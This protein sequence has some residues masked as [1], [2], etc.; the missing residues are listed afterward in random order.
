[1]QTLTITNFTRIK[2]NPLPL[3]RQDLQLLL[4]RVL[5]MGASSFYLRQ[6]FLRTFFTFVA[7]IAHYIVHFDLIGQDCSIQLFVKGFRFCDAIVSASGRQLQDSTSE[8][9]DF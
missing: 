1:M 4:P 8:P 2:P 9:V 7:I 6:S 5:E 3:T